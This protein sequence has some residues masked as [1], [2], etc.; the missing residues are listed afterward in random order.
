MLGTEERIVL[1]IGTREQ[2]AAP[3]CAAGPP[4]RHAAQAPAPS[5]PKGGP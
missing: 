5:P 4:V 1:A 2:A 3:P